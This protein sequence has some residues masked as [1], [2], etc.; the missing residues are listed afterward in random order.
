MEHWNNRINGKA[1]QI[2]VLLTK[3]LHPGWDS[4]HIRIG[5]NIFWHTGGNQTKPSAMSQ[6]AKKKKNR[7]T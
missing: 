7:G 4:Q 2:F 3:I 1:N 5:E 6:I